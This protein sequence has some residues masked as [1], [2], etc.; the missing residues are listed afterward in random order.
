MRFVRKDRGVHERELMR[1]EGE[2]RSSHARRRVALALTQSTFKFL[3]IALRISFLAFPTVSSLVSV[4]ALENTLL[5]VAWPV[6]PSALIRR[7]RLSARPP[8]GPF[9]PSAR[10]PLGTGASSATCAS[11]ASALPM[12]S[13][14]LPNTAGVYLV[15]QTQHACPAELQRHSW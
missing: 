14:L 13:D 7:S 10:P 1:S 4:A 3:P 12:T 6:G 9:R 5:L 2:S 11:A 8:F 15:V